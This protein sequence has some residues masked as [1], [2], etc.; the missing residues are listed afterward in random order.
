MDEIRKTTV[1]RRLLEGKLFLESVEML[2]RV[3]GDQSLGK[4]AELRIVNRELLDLELQEIGDQ[5]ERLC[6]IN[7]R[8]ER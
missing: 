1:R 8:I 4:A 5:I 3:R 7:A 6:A 2:R